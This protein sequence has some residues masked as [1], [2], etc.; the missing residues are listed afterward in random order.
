MYATDFEYDG[1]RLS[2][3]GYIVCTFDSGDG[4]TNAS[5]GNEL[6]FNQVARNGGRRFGL[7]SS[8]YQD[9]Y[10]T[11]FGIC[12][13]PDKTNPD[14][15]EFADDEIRSLMRW[16][17]RA[18]FHKF[19]T[20]SDIERDTLYYNVSFNLEKVVI[21][22]KVVGMQVHLIA[23]RPFGYGDTETVNLSLTASQTASFNMISDEIGHFYPKIEIT[24]GE[25]GDL[26]LT[27]NMT[28]SK[29]IINNCAANE[30]IT[31]SGDT[32]IVSTNV[33]THHLYDDFNFEFPTIGNEY[34]NNTNTFTSTLACTIK[35]QYEPIIKS[36]Y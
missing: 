16:L 30:K 9:P 3:L 19:R 2:A 26:T 24:I 36:S 35:I 33:Q 12:K 13:D 21:A 29:T 5:I 25:A 32:E 18:D 27:N 8:E 10:E 7:T 22:E 4:F 11:D 14:E 1:V 28:G 23:D 34:L 6:T 20:Y 17:N 15:M 31:F